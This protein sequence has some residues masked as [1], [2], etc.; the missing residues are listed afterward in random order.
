MA[1]EMERVSEYWCYLLQKCPF[2]SPL[3]FFFS[4]A[5]AFIDRV[6]MYLLFWDLRR[7]VEGWR[8]GKDEM[9]MMMTLFMNNIFH[10]SHALILAPFCIYFSTF[11]LIIIHFYARHAT[12][13]K[14]YDWSCCHKWD[15]WCP[16]KENWKIILIFTILLKLV[17]MLQDF[18][19]PLYCILSMSHWPAPIYQKLL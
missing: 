11:Y 12:Y 17:C 9:R 2:R 14:K 1:G 8:N 10:P 6:L 15:C 5:F 4:V 7:W 13:L 3:P 16:L 19:C 18:S